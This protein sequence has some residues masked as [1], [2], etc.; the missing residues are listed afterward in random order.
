MGGFLLTSVC[1]LS[2]V[3]YCWLCVCTHS[4]RH[5]I[6]QGKQLS[7]EWEDHGLTQLV[8]VCLCGMKESTQL[9]PQSPLSLLRLPLLFDC[10]YQ[11]EQILFFYLVV[12][13]TPF[14]LIL[15]PPVP[16]S[17]TPACFDSLSLCWATVMWRRLNRARPSYKIF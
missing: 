10:L 6:L 13:L 3:N 15:T 8:S 1:L 4:V 16:L 7:T 9:M 12:P 14:T 5:R 17:N 11:A 2:W